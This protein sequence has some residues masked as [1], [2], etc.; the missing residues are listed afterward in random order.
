MNATDGSQ[1]NPLSIDKRGAKPAILNQSFILQNIFGDFVKQKIT[2]N[3]TLGPDSP[4]LATFLHEL[5]IARRQLSLYPPGHPQIETSVNR[6]LEALEELF[7]SDP[8]IT[9]GISPDAL[10]FGQLWLDKD[11]P[12][13]REFAKIF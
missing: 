3:S 11:D 2:D 8:V 7:L 12:T 4:L 13:N 5:N 10:Y 6:T 1:I 9:I